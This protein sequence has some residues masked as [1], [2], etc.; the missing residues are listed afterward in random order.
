MI[1]FFKRFQAPKLPPINEDW[2]AGDWAT[3]IVEGS[4]FHFGTK[5]LVAEVRPVTNFHTQMPDWGLRIVGKPAP[6][7]QKWIASCFRKVTPDAFEEPRR[8]AVRESEHASDALPYLI[9]PCK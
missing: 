9:G 7:D 5:W 4:G 6:F 8:A 3:P 1:N 2:K